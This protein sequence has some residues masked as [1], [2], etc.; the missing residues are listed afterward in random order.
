MRKEI[1][2]LLALF[3]IAATTAQTHEDALLFSENAVVGT[4]RTAAMSNAF[5]ALGAD[6]S[7]LSNNP[8]GLGVYQ[9]YEFAFSLNLGGVDMASYYLDNKI[10][11]SS[12]NFNI[13]SV[14]LVTPLKSS[15]SSDWRR[16]NLGFAYNTTK[17]FKANT[18]QSAYNP[19]SSLV[20]VFYAFAD[21]YR[22]DDLDPFFELAAFD[23][24]LIDLQVDSN[25]WI[26]DGNY[27][28]EVQTGQDQFKQT[29]TFG[30]MG[31]FAISYAGS[32]MEKLYLGATLGLTSTEY[33]KKSRYNERNFAD[34]SSTVEYFDM[35]ENQ[36][37]TGG[38]VNL[39]LGAIY[40]ASDNLRLGVAWH[41][42]TLNEMH[43]EWEVVLRTQHNNDS[44]YSYT[45]TSPY[46]VYDYTITTPMKVIGSAA[47]V[48]D[49]ILLS[50]DIEYVDYATMSIDGDDFDYFNNQQNIIE[51]N[52]TSV[53]NARFGAELN[54][55]PFVIRAGYAQVKS[56]YTD[57][58]TFNTYRDERKSYSF[59]VGKRN[60]FSY[61]DL[62][63][64]FSEY[65]NSASLYNTYFEPAHRVTT[66]AY[67]LVFTMGWKF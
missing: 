19:N 29:H 15:T 27:F 37:T 38:G 24:D 34:T 36:Y 54:L 28:R 10:T 51:S 42:P 56:P 58:S 9:S 4:A 3:T 26:D 17:I 16:T 67:N 49:N 65:S 50:G 23:T 64:V 2:S 48:L 21:G 1:L 55:S 62:A 12:G 20:D 14:G 52:Y 8:A 46:G 5:G 31:E 47:L 22:L 66:T 45:Y 32:Y 43:D 60:Q 35:Y 25:G 59:G 6:L 41:S 40:R 61:I 39:K 11:N 53:V 44:T 57:A 33:T 30:S 13:P 7:T 63:Y 18:I